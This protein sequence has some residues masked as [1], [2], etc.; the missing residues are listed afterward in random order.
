MRLCKGGWLRTY[1]E[2]T[3]KQESPEIFHL[4]VGISVIAGA[5]GRNCYINRGYFK[6]Y[7]NQYIALVSQSALCKKGTACE[8][9]T[10]IYN[11]AFPEHPV[12]DRKLTMQKLVGNLNKS[13]KEL[14]YSFIYLYNEEL[15]T[16]FGRGAVNTE[17]MDF[18]TSVYGCKERWL[19]ETASRGEE[20]LEKIYVNFLACTTPSDLAEMPPSL[21]GGG[22]AGRMI[23]VYS[24]TPRNCVPNPAIH[25][26]N[27]RYM[28][29]QNL[30]HDLQQI[31]K[32]QREF[33][34]TDEA[35]TL[36]DKLY[37][38]NFERDD[39]D[40]RLEPYKGR[41]GE[42]LLK[43][44]MIISASRSDE[45]IIDKHDLEAADI[46][47]KQIESSIIDAFIGV[48][49]A[50]EARNTDRIL[51]CIRR[52]GGRIGHAELL[53]K[54]YRWMRAKEAKDALDTLLDAG[55]I[56]LKLEGGKKVW[57]ML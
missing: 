37:R 51:A 42:H 43:L 29:R 30:I 1:L 52:A 54:V 46:F 44:S 33:K 27:E 25:F 11:E 7:P 14:G 4:W 12:I 13:R 41:K 6:T 53:R 35:W 55:M 23:F 16:L 18:L 22:L 31:A 56:T 34:L 32:I 45:G 17:L 21:V 15:S 40:F 39:Y 19:Y 8:I 24:D 28:M 20:W 48:G 3:D 47:L 57:E 36:Y 38:E 10:G 5:L 9:G 2:Y 49:H 26:T 50:E